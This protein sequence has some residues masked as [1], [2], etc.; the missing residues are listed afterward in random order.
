MVDSTLNILMI[1]FSVI[2]KVF[3]FQRKRTKFNALDYLT[4]TLY[5]YVFHCKKIPI[6][7]EKKLQ[8]IPPI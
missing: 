7:Y 6:Y 5:K 3:L 8:T 1:C 2:F 4:E